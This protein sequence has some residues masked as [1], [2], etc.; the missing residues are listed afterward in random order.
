MSDE[1]LTPTVPQYTA[2][3]RPP[4]DVGSL[5]Y[6]AVFGGALAATVLGLINGYRLGVGMARQALVA[7]AGTAVI[8]LRIVAAVAMAGQQ[9]EMLPALNAAAGILVWT[10]TRATQLRA[11]RAF[12]LRGGEP[13]GLWRPGLA[14]TV[15]GGLLEGLLTIAA[16]YLVNQ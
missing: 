14:A 10:A 4:W 2:R 13:A 1:L 11:G 12:L 3:A 15:G 8:A 6:P 9:Y 16:G 5:L 7:I